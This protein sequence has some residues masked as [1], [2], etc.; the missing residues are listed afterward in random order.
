MKI[1][2]KKKLKFEPEGESWESGARLWIIQK[3]ILKENSFR[4]NW[5][6]DEFFSKPK[7]STIGRL[8]IGKLL[9]ETV[10]NNKEKFDQKS[11]GLWAEAW[12]SIN[13]ISL[14]QE[15][16]KAE[17]FEPNEKESLFDDISNA[18]NR[19]SDT[20]VSSNMSPNETWR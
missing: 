17:C 9:V 8:L 3:L 7:S 11:F 4:G 19:F 5:S 1:S 13:Q 10:S 18:F 15:H 14:K 6:W 2:L 20:S 12:T 16:G